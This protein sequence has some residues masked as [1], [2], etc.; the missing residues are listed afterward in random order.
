MAR[1]H[2]KYMGCLGFPPGL[3]AC[4]P[5]PASSCSP[6]SEAVLRPR[7]RGHWEGHHYFSPAHRNG[8]S[9]KLRVCSPRRCSFTPAPT[10]CGRRCL[11]WA[12]GAQPRAPASQAKGWSQRGAALLRAEQ[13]RGS[14]RYCASTS[15]PN[16]PWVPLCSGLFIVFS[17]FLIAIPAR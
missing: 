17:P 3:S 5:P 4:P 8:R 13:E 10:P 7:D 11:L 12:A 14:R 15:A 9:G 6:S 2:P 1:P 16:Q